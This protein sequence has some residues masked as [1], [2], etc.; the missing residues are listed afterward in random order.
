MESEYSSIDADV[1]AVDCTRQTSVKLM[2]TPST[3]DDNSR[4]QQQ[5]QRPKTMKLKKCSFEDCKETILRGKSGPWMCKYHR[6]KTYKETYKK[7][8]GKTNSNHGTQQKKMCDRSSPT[9]GGM[10]NSRDQQEHSQKAS[11]MGHVLNEKKLALMKSPMVQAF[12]QDQQNSLC[13]TRQRTLGL[14]SHMM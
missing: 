7:K 10:Y 11:M 8:K 4:D 6:N 5:Q 1:D 13:N 14:P 2:A 9:L 12:L 3:D